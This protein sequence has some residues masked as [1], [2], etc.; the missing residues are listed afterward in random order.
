RS[1]ITPVPGQQTAAK[2][3]QLRQNAVMARKLIHNG[4]MVFETHAGAEV[5]FEDIGNST[6]WGTLG[7]LHIHGR[8]LLLL[9]SACRL[10]RKGLKNDEI[11]RFK[12]P[13]A[14]L[15]Y[16]RIANSTGNF[17]CNAKG[18]AGSQD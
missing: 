1:H 18:K 5:E 8:N 13:S 16:S 9:S 3:S 11:G 10:T 2:L 17:F 15:N 7:D 12:F 4:R 14:R 6:R